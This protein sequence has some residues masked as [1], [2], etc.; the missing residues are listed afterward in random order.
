MKLFDLCDDLL[1]TIADHVFAYRKILLVKNLKRSRNHV[2]VLSCWSLGA[3]HKTLTLRTDGQ[4]LYSYGLKIGITEKA[5]KSVLNYT[6]RG[7]NYV[8][9]TTSTHVNK[10]CA[11]ADKMILLKDN[12]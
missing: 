9:H 12:L 8:S 10:A 6:A 7:N 2:A 5:Y 4:D 3:P 1:E 11:F